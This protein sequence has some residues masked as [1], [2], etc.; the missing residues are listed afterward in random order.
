[1]G[2]CIMKIIL[3]IIVILLCASCRATAPCPAYAREYQVRH[4]RYWKNHRRVPRHHQTKI[5]IIAPKI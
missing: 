2:G 1:M 5:T 4:P 3:A